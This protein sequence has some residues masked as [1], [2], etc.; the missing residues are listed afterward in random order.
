VAAIS[1][2]ML[3]PVIAATSDIMFSMVAAIFGVV[4]APTIFAV[5]ALANAD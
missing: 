5:N 3:A 4:D 2:V 1:V